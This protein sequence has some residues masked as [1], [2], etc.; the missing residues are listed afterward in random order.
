MVMAP[1][2]GAAQGTAEGGVLG[3]AKGFFVGLGKGVIGGAALAVG[4][5]ATGVYQMGRGV[6]HTPGGFQASMEG[7]EWDPEKMAWVHYNLVEEA[8]EVVDVSDEEFLASLAKKV[9]GE[10]SGSSEGKTETARYTP[11]KAVKELEFYEI[12]GVPSSASAAEIKKAYYVKAKESHPDRHRDDPNAHSK[13]QKIGE[14]YQVLS[15]EKLRANYDREGKD[16]VEG[17]PKMDA[18]SM[19]AMIFGS[20]KFEPLIGESVSYLSFLCCHFQYL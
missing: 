12:L 4:G 3:G 6:Y 14:A 1:I 19:Y 16:G 8:R 13:F 2:Q 10:T 18:S 11:K 20:E 17:A 5:V 7:K 9:G 15:D